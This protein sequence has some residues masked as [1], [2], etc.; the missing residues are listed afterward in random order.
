MDTI[1]TFNDLHG[2]SWQSFDE[3]CLQNPDTHLSVVIYARYRRHH[4][5]ERCIYG[6][7]PI[8]EAR[9]CVLVR[10]PYDRLVQETVKAL[11]GG[12]VEEEAGWMV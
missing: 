5:P 8:A 11:V 7:L 9:L 10:N 6:E 3:I 2:L 1:R 4:Q 12:V